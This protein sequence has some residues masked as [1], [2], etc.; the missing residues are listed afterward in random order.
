[1]TPNIKSPT[2]VV[3]IKYGPTYNNDDKLYNYWKFVLLT[4]LYSLCN[5]QNI[6][7]KLN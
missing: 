1:M 5:F 7:N 4:C 6:E 3:E 2:Y